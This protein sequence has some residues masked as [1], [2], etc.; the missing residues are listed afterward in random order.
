MENI[1]YR[2]AKCLLPNSYPGIKFNKHG[3]CNFCSEHKQKEL[4]GE[5]LFLKKINSKHGKKYDCVVGISGGKDSCYVA[6]L[7]KE[8]FNLR[9]LAVFY[10]FPFF[11]NLARQNV[12]NVCNT[13]N[14]DLIIQKTKKNLEYDLLRNHLMSTAATGTSW[15]Q[16]LFCHYGIDA[17]LYNMANKENIPFILSGVTKDELWWDPGNRATILL[18]RIKKL[19]VNEKAKF[20]FYQL[21]AY[22]D[23]VAQ[24]REFRLPSNSTLIAYKKP[25]TPKK[26]PEVIKIFEYIQ[27]DQ[28]TI[29]DTLMKRAG[30]IKPNRFSW[31]YDCILEPLLDYTYKKEFGISTVGLYLSGLIRSN[32]IDRDKALKILQKSED[33]EVLREAVKHV[34]NFLKIPTSFQE[35]FFE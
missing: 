4:Y 35:S 25:V 30:W 33:E 27:W 5:D 20:I 2:C 22:L 8:H 3:V 10:D 11:R 13:L 7:A 21:K 26:G 17:I 34:F 9:V 6:Y 19:P 15:G 14:I 18:K 12:K 1:S 29:E 31:R 24:R 28:K 16:C 32:Q 23:L